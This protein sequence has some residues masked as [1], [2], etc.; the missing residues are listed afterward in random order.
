VPLR[1]ARDVLAGNVVVIA[2]GAEA[3]ATVASVERKRVFRRA[4]KLTLRVSWVQATDGESVTLRSASAA[5]DRGTSGDVVDIAAL[6]GAESPR[7]GR[8]FVAPRGTEL[9]AYVDE[10]KVLGPR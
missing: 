9:V 6:S 3:S 4:P 5:E 2:R 10:L 7:R 1:V 8:D